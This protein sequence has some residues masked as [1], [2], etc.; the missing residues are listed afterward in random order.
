MSEKVKPK[1]GNGKWIIIGV[2]GCLLLIFGCCLM[3]SICALLS[4]GSF[5]DTTGFRF[6]STGTEE[7]DPFDNFPDD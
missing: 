2:C 7:D 1:S 5:E 3:T 6:D 4:P